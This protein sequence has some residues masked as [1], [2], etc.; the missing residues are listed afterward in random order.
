MKFKKQSRSILNVSRNPARQ[1]REVSPVLFWK[2]EKVF[3]ILDKKG[4][5]DTA[6]L[7]VKFYIQHIVLKI[8]RKKAGKSL[9]PA[10][11]PKVCCNSTKISPFS[12]KFLNTRLVNVNY[13]YIWK[14]NF[15]ILILHKRPHQSGLVKSIFQT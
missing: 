11:I 4:P 8:F 14:I 6:H 9:P 13:Q 12:K 7:S 3:L 1:R 5:D 2:W 15:K 10:K